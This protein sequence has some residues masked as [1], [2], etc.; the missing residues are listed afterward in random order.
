MQSVDSVAA[1]NAGESVGGKA[2]QYLTQRT[3]VNQRTAITEMKAGVVA[4]AAQDQDFF[5]RYKALTLRKG[6]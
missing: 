6:Q 4:F 2:G 5:N 1:V 3:G